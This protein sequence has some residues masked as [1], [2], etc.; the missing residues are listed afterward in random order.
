MISRVSSVRRE[1]SVLWRWKSE[2]GVS[3]V[4]VYGVVCWTGWRWG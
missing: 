1:D 2:A 4:G 3:G